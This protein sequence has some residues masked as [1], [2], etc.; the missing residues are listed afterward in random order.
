MGRREKKVV[1]VFITLAEQIIRNLPC[2][3][4]HSHSLT[5]LSLNSEKSRSSFK[6]V[7]FIYLSHHNIIL[8]R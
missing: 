5:R 1:P 6:S 8:R 2:D 7:P 3:I 4:Y